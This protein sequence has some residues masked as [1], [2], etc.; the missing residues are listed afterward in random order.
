M[1]PRRWAWK[2]LVALFLMIGAM[3]CS[4]PMTGAQT[5][6]DAPVDGSSVPVGTPVAI[7]AHAYAPE[8]VAEVL[9]S[10]NGA[11]YRRNPPVQ[12]GGT[13]SEAK[14]EWFPQ[15][16]GDYVIQVTAFSS[17]GQATSARA[18]TVRAI[19]KSTPTPVP[20]ISITP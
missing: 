4:Q 18:V 8:G 10:V 6:I 3:G 7:L 16:E 17:S 14:L 20:I 13:F 19:G 2:L 9:L 5:W 15:Q 12:P 1:H 11:A